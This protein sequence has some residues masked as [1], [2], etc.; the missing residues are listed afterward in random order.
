M[1]NKATY[2]LTYLLNIPAGLCRVAVAG[3]GRAEELSSPNQPRVCIIASFV[4]KVLH[5]LHT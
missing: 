1:Q 4:F 5:L 3:E 2:L